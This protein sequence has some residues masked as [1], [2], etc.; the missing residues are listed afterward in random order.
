MASTI[1]AL[2]L[3]TA[4]SKCKLIVIPCQLAVPLSLR[5][6]TRVE[7]DALADCVEK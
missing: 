7:H 3:G 1:V 6:D 5:V 2:Q 4:C